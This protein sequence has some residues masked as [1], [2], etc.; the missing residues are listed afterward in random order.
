MA[1]KYSWSLTL[2]AGTP[3][4]TQELDA[5]KALGKR[6]LEKWEAVLGRHKLR[7]ARFSRNSVD[8][9]VVCFLSHVVV[10]EN[11]AAGLPALWRA[12]DRFDQAC[13]D[14]PGQGRLTQASALGLAFALRRTR[15]A[16]MMLD[17]GADPNRYLDAGLPLNAY[18]RQ[19]SAKSD[20]ALVRL[21]VRHGADP[22]AKLGGHAQGLSDNL[23]KALLNRCQTGE[24]LVLLEPLEQLPVAVISKHESWWQ[25][26]FGGA[27]RRCGEDLG[28]N[29][30]VNQLIER[31]MQLGLPAP[32][33]A[34]VLVDFPQVS[35]REQAVAP[36]VALVEAVLALTEEHTHAWPWLERYPHLLRAPLQSLLE[37]HVLLQ[38]TQRSPG[39]TRPRL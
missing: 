11:W 15:C 21:F 29:P 17:L 32:R 3:V 5:L 22:F 20:P 9:K 27:T 12:G 10:H 14:P 18:P 24:A 6:D 31:L 25:A 23:L 26:L 8:G 37:Q 28:Q 7:P 38:D 16:A 1:L 33:L 13:L 36:F 4:G 35:A 30:P 19:W 2:T 34:D 39:L